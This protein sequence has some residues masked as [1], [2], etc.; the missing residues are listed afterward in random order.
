[1][2]GHVTVTVTRSKL[3]PPVARRGPAW[4]WFYEA[5]GE[6]GRRFDNRSIVTLR[7]VLRKRY[8]RDVRIVETWGG[9]KA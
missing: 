7:R 3:Y 5:Q 8:G 1:M 4:V 2:A 9:G 6:D